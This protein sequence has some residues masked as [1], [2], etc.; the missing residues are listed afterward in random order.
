MSPKLEAPEAQPQ[1]MSPGLGLDDEARLT[2]YLLCSS[3][4]RIET[5]HAAPFRTLN[6]KFGARLTAYLLCSS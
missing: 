2:A 6:P 5:R 3:V 4:A 1:P